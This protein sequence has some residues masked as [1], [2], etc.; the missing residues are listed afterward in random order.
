MRESALIE[1]SGVAL[2]LSMARERSGGP[3]PASEVEQECLRLANELGLEPFAAARSIDDFERG[4]RKQ[5]RVFRH[6]DILRMGML[7]ARQHA[8]VAYLQVYPNAQ[9]RPKSCFVLEQIR[10]ELDAQFD[11]YGLQE[12]F[13]MMP[14]IPWPNAPETWKEWSGDAM[15]ACVIRELDALNATAPSDT[16]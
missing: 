5:L 11:K 1:L 15:R 3:N 6:K 8:F 9:N 7:L 13:L 14:H 4:W 10:R 16:P 2:R 12:A